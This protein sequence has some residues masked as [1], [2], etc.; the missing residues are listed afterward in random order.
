MKKHYEALDGLRGVAALTVAVTHAWL[1]LGFQAVPHGY[2]AVDFF[3][4]LSGFVIAHAYEQ[5]L[6]DGMGLSAFLKARTIRLYPMI[7]LGVLAG[8]LTTLA[9]VRPPLP[10]LIAT[11][12]VQLFVFPAPFSHGL[13]F[14]L[15]PLD[16]P[17]WSLFWEFLVNIAFAFSLTHWSNR[18]LVALCLLSAAGL[19][20]IALA[21]N[22]LE[23]GFTL[24]SLP[25]GG[26]R[27]I[28]SFTLGLLLYRAHKAEWLPRLRMNLWVISAALVG[29]FTLPFRGGFVDLA[30]V[31][32]G[33][34]ALLVAAISANGDGWFWSWS[35]R[36]S[37]PLYLIHY[38]LLVTAL[39]IQP[40]S[41]PLSVR[42]TWVIGFALAALALAAA[43]L[44]AYDEPVRRVLNLRPVPIQPQRAAAE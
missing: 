35:G 15:W 10:G 3:F 38:P 36:L 41:L 2:L 4:A 22:S 17:S 14:G 40:A 30:I 24:A 1:L 27:A 8:T 32:I 39:A 25:A 5:R 42:V 37:Y 13:G 11:M 19:A 34:P 29:C 21:R 20:A 26:T 44:L 12:A 33:L 6:R 16:P 43:T 9:T 7:V 31:L 28:F 18:R 23:L